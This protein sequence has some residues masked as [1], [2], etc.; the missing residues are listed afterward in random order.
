MA[1][2]E[3]YK[4]RRADYTGPYEEY[5]KHDPYYQGVF[6]HDGMKMEF[7]KDLEKELWIE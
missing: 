7:W 1:D 5:K 4:A 6:N 2:F 3:A